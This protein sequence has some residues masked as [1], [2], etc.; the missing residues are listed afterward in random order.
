MCATRVNDSEGPL[1]QEAYDWGRIRSNVR[2]VF[3]INS[4]NT[5]LKDGEGSRGDIGNL[6]PKG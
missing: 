5:R 2:S 3:V 4:V 6:R 1:P